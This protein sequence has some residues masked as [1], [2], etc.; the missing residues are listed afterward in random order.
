VRIPAILAISLGAVLAS[1]LVIAGPFSG[2]TVVSRHEQH[3]HEADAAVFPLSIRDRF[4]EK[5]MEGDA[6]ADSKFMKVDEDFVDPENHCEF[7]TRV[8]YTS[9]PQGK[10]GFSYE[11]LKGLDLSGAKKVRFWAMGEQGDEKIK[12]KVAGRS[13]DKLQEKPGKLK[14]ELNSIF[15]SERFALTTDQVTLQKNWKRY[16][17]DLT[18]SDLKGITDPFA[19]ELSANG[20]QKQVVFIKGVVYDNKP[21]QEPLMATA[22]DLTEPL[23]AKIISNCTEGFAPATFDFRANVTGGTEP[24]STKW[25]FGDGNKSSNET[26]SHTFEKAG[27]YKVTLEL[28]DA[29]GRTASDGLEIQLKEPVD[30]KEA[31]SNRTDDNASNSTN[32]T[33]Q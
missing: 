4:T 6:A 22:E 15:K 21:A 14:S 10:A 9:G 12:I 26:E 7:C 2:N 8:E 1:S 20:A 28:A 31:P 30:L 25:D 5:Q 11:D 27:T 18:G 16:E 17:I 3:S 23:T 19:F 33:S 29:G 13:I 24:Y 32:S